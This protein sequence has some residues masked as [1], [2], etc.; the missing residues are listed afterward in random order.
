M[1]DRR[2]FLYLAAA[3]AVLPFTVGSAGSSGD[4]HRWTPTRFDLLR[5]LDDETVRAIGA[6]YRSSTPAEDDPGVLR[7]RLGAGSPDT[8]IR[9]DFAAGRTVV[10][11]GWVLSITEARQCALFSLPSA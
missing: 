9:A 1:L 3:A 6:R 7:R 10:V 11:D 4:R 8:E 2:R 5:A